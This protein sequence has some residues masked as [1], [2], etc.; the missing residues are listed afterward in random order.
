MLVLVVDNSRSSASRTGAEARPRHLAGCNVVPGS[1]R[2]CAA[3]FPPPC[4][5]NSLGYRGAP[6]TVT[7][8][9][10]RGQPMDRQ[11]A[12]RLPTGGPGGL[13]P[14][15]HRRGVVG[16]AVGVSRC[17][18]G[19]C[20]PLTVSAVALGVA[21]PRPPGGHVLSRREG[22]WWGCNGL[23]A[24]D[25]RCR[26]QGAGRKSDR[27]PAS[28]TSKGRPCEPSCRGG[29]SQVMGLRL[30]PWVS[31]PAQGPSCCHS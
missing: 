1:W 11:A 4:V 19:V 30:V 8:R 9:V 15:C 25:A 31:Q 22:C 29:A 13:C 24:R 21:T 18:G 14:G 7:L 20:G 3:R 27:A 26:G 23:F 12:H 16:W 17:D 28:L 6:P 5:T 10:A 2:W